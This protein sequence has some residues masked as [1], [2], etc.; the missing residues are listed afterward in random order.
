[1]VVPAAS[2]VPSQVEPEV[3]GSGPAE[4]DVCAPRDSLAPLEKPQKN[5]GDTDNKNSGPRITPMDAD[6]GRTD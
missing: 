5:E 2:E 6:D 4:D 1:V 3:A